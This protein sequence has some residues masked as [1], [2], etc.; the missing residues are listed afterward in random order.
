MRI[1]DLDFFLVGAARSGTTTMWHLLVRT[2]GLFLPPE[3]MKKEPG[4][5]SELT[6]F[7]S[8]DRYLRLFDGAEED[9]LLGEASTAYLTDPA[10]ASR[11]ADQLPDARI[12]IMLR[13]PADRAYS[14]YNWMVQEGYEWITSFEEALRREPDRASDERFRE[15]NPQYFYNYL[16]FRSGLYADQVERFYRLFGENQVHVALFEDFIRRPGET[17]REVLQFLG[18]P[19]PDAVPGVRTLNPSR[20][21]VSARLQ[22]ALRRV[23]RWI[24][25]LRPGSA[26]SKERR[27]FLLRWGLTDESPPPL[28]P[29]LRSDLL[30]AYRADVQRLQRLLAR[31]LS[32]WMEET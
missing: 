1:A 15:D 16:Y 13:N 9:G 12:L 10:A 8:R 29:D 23:T 24:Q 11:I 18:A 4:Y 26:P 30:D 27:D 32:G 3:M 2:P 20:E 25:I 6:G 21:P 31:D 22:Y 28:P 19:A 7:R 14:L 5:F 17:Y